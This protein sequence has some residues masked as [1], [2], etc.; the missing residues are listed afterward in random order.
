ML[1]RG[2]ATLQ[3]QAIVDSYKGANMNISKTC[4]QLSE[5]LLVRIDGKKTYENLEFEQDQQKH[6]DGT[7]NRLHEMH[8][9][10][11]STMKTT[12]EVFRTDG[13][14]VRQ[15]VQWAVNHSYAGMT[16]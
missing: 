16:T 10:I 1:E 4:K 8:R 6:R 9:Q 12:Y 5:T 7:Q 15:S 3:I 14:E 13:N 11:V 2:I